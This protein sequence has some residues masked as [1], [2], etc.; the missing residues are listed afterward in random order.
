MTR[1]ALHR[2]RVSLGLTQAEVSARVQA[3][4]P[5]VRGVSRS[6]L[7]RFEGL[8]PGRS[9]SDLQLEAWAQALGLELVLLPLDPAEREAD[10]RARLAQLEGASRPA[11]RR[12]RAA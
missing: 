9:P 1:Q 3:A 7:A 4:R 11:P 8:Q 10:L 2:R 5:E 6:D 12:R